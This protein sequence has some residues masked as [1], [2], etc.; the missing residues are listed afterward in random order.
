MAA[1]GT[2]HASK[3]SRWKLLE[4]RLRDQIPT[5][6]HLTEAH[7]ELQRLIGE[8][9]ELELLFEK[10]KGAFND[11]SARRKAVIQAGEEL[12]ARLAGAL[13]F[14]LGPKSKTLQEFG[15]KPRR[16]GGRRKARQPGEETPEPE[17]PKPAASEAVVQAEE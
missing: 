16:P 7:A 8:A 15:L 13:Y 4:G 5:Q 6:P 10:S 2:S 3:I 14:K 1:Q 11:A 9:E 12:R 17:A